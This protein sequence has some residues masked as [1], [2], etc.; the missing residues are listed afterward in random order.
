MKRHP[1]TKEV[2]TQ[3]AMWRY[4]FALLLILLHLGNT[5]IAQ[6]PEL[7]NGVINLNTK[8]GAGQYKSAIEVSEDVIKIAEKEHVD[9]VIFLRHLLVDF[10]MRAYD[11]DCA[12]KNI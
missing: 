2:T 11:P 3:V 10:C 9:A 1:Y 8:F 5:A 12:A 7:V 4:V 6:S